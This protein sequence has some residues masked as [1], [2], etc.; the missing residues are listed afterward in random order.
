MSLTIH[1]GEQLQGNALKKM[2]RNFDDVTASM[3]RWRTRINERDRECLVQA[4]A[5]FETLLRII[6]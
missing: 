2:R 1:Q 3:P 4:L 5:D 6:G